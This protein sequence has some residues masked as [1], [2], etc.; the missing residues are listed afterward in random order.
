MKIGWM[1]LDKKAAALRAVKDYPTMDQIIKNYKLAVMDTR[2]HMQAP[3]SSILS[4]APGSSGV[5]AAEEGRVAGAIDTL[6]TLAER[7]QCAVDYMA[8]FRPAWD[9]LNDT[10]HIILSEFYHTDYVSRNDLISGLSRTLF[11]ERAQI[12]RYKDKALERLAVSLYG[13]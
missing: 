12:Y 8:W 11:L 5:L 1:Y 3:R 4:L 9:A 13:L 6:D 7:Y 10:E 2:T